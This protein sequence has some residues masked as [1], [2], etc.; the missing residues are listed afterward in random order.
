MPQISSATTAASLHLD[1][2]VP[3]LGGKP[4]NS[5]AMRVA[6]DF[7]SV[8][9]A[10]FTQIM[11]SGLKTDG[12]FGGGPS[13]D[14]YRSLLAEEYGKALAKSG[15]FGIADSVYRDIIRYQEVE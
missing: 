10:Q 4:T 15:N 14:I 2:K 3:K 6:K 7:E 11:F 1:P 8:F 9:L 13:E 5:E 12:P